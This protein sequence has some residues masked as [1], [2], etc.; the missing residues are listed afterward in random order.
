MKKNTN[1][2]YTIRLL[3]WTSYWIRNIIQGHVAW[4][5][6]SR[7]VYTLYYFIVLYFLMQITK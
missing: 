2:K 3:Y 4:F 1:N 5:L 7:C 6:T